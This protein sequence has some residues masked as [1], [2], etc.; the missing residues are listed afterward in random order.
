MIPKKSDL[1]SQTGRKLWEQEFGW[2][3]K[4]KE[5]KMKPSGISR[6][7]R[8]EKVFEEKEII[9]TIGKGDLFTED[10]TAPTLSSSPN[11]TVDEEVDEFIPELIKRPI[12]VEIS[13]PTGIIPK[14]SHNYCNL[15][16][17]VRY[18]RNEGVVGEENLAVAMSLALINKSPFGVEGYSGSGKT[19][20]TNKLI[21]LVE[22][23]VYRIGLSSN[24]AIFRDSDKI[25]DKQIIYIPELQKAM[26]R[27]NSPII[28]AIKDITEGQDATRIVTKKS[29]DGTIEYRIKSGICIIYTLAL[30]NNFKKDPETSRRFIRL[31]TDSSPDHIDAIHDDKARRR[32]S[33]VEPE[34]QEE[35]EE[36]LKSHLDYCLGLEDLKIIDPFSD[37][38]SSLVPR[39]QKSI[40]YVDHY[41]SL[42]DACAKFHAH[43]RTVV[44]SEGQKYLMINLEDHHTVF[45]VYFGE[46]IK[47]L[48]EFSTDKDNKE[49]MA[50]L[51][52]FENLE[53]PDW[54]LAFTEGMELVETEP[55]L[56]YLASTNKGSFEKWID[57]QVVDGKLYSTDHKTGQTCQIAEMR[58]IR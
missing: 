10:I 50:E 12:D 5:K 14:R 4:K 25:N 28:E 49:E 55:S 30:E 42:L 2:L 53:Q 57:D 43:E 34:S 47:T 24:Q 26:K 39:T 44:E 40:G 20:V 27:K 41:Y 18:F 48:K 11:P 17:I 51:S 45:N 58:Y 16:D 22:D 54:S 7:I 19:F 21:E 31:R 15:H 35:L 52:Y 8:E 3:D 1:R 37:Y 38:I 29:G 56:K 13:V 9:P 32:Y 46:F 23:K 33:L 36:K 6:P